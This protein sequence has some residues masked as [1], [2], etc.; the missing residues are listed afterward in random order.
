MKSKWCTV[1]FF[2]GLLSIGFSLAAQLFAQEVLKESLI[3]STK[4]EVNEK[5][6]APD[7]IYCEELPTH[8]FQIVKP[9]MVD[10]LKST[11]YYN[12]PLHDLYFI[13]RN[14][15]KLECRIFY[16]EEFVHG[17]TVYRAKEQLIKFLDTPVPLGRVSEYI[18]EFKPAYQCKKVF[19]ERLVNHDNI[20]LVFLTEEI[21]DRTNHYGSLFVD[22]DKDIKDWCLAYEIILIEGEPENVNANSMVEE[23][24]I[25][26]YGEYRLGKTSHI[27][28]TKM[29]KNPLQ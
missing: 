5:L 23:V 8:R 25:K 3:L 9:D 21:T 6:G 7:Y 20:R 13:N 16:G 4:A 2:S 26:I 15:S 18:P 24:V 14:G 27:F 12:V 10:W 1:L 11:F 19:R 22:P 29:I 17:K 28:D